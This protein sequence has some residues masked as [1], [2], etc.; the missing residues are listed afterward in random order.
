MMNDTTLFYS[1]MA[2]AS[3]LYNTK[4]KQPPDSPLSFNLRATAISSNNEALSDPETCRS[5]QTIPSICILDT[6]ES[7]YGDTSSYDIHMTGVVKLVQLR[8]GLDYLGMNGLLARMIVWL[9][10]HHSKLHGTNLYFDQSTA[11][12]RRP[13]PVTYP[14]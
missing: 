11:V 5:N 12:G 9:D 4:R 6:A 10:F 1:S 14:N 13:S 2:F 8:G 3:S 7:F